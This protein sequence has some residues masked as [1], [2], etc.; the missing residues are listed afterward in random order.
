MRLQADWY[1]NASALGAQTDDGA[2]KIDQAWVMLGGFAAGYGDSLYQTQFNNS[3]WNGG[4]FSWSGMYYNGAQF[5]QMRYEFGSKQGFSGAISLENLNDQTT[6]VPNIVGRLTYGG[7]WGT[8]GLAVAY[9]PDRNGQE[10]PGEDDSVSVEGA[11]VLNVP[12]M[13]GSAFKVMGWYNSAYTDDYS[14]GSPWG[15]LL[16]TGIF[17]T[18]E[19]SVMASFLYQATPDL[20]L[21]VSGQYFSNIYAFD[22]TDTIDNTTAWA[23]EVSAVWTPV[24]NF[25][26]RPEIVYTK[27]KGHDGSVSGFLRFTRSF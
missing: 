8:A 25:E 15:G 5:A 22:S 21:I 11:V 14:E 27:A 12:S 24:K 13:P 23:A 17:A 3:G 20:G 7:A 18:P 10:I 26:I 2:V 1:P 16:P 9:D 4:S 6:Y 19:W